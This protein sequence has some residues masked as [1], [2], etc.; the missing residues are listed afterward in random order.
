MKVVS[1]SI[2]SLEESMDEFEEAYEAARKRLP[3]KRHDGVSF[4]SIEV[5]RNFLTP[6]RLEILRCVKEKKPQSVY[7]LAKLLGRGFPSVLR[8]IEILHK[9]GLVKLP[10]AKKSPRR[11]IA[12]CVDYDA[13]DIRIAL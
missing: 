5:M 10:K 1:F 9:H 3:F 12:P 2:K 6:K 7:A 13:I 4:T 8:D 11:A